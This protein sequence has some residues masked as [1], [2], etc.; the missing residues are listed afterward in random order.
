M[1]YR[2]PP[3]ISARF[4]DSIDSHLSHQFA[5]LIKMSFYVNIPRV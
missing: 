5:P 3:R 1:R 4:A 2:P